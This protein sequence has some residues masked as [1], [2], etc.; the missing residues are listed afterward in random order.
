MISQNSISR[1]SFWLS[2]LR[3]VWLMSITWHAKLQSSFLHGWCTPC[4]RLTIL[5]SV[6]L[7]EWY[8]V[9]IVWSYFCWLL[10]Q[11]DSFCLCSSWAPNKTLSFAIQIVL[12]IAQSW[13]SWTKA[14]KVGDF[15]ISRNR[16]LP[17]KQIPSHEHFKAFYDVKTIRLIVVHTFLWFWLWKMN[18][19]NY[20]WDLLRKPLGYVM[21]WKLWQAT[22]QSD[23]TY[24]WKDSSL[25]PEPTISSVL[26]FSYK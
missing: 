13:C 8:L 17:K 6:C 1:T 14:Y 2:Y 5:L 21:D 12:W 16:S 25:Y 19:F 3:S 20:S 22:L 24:L 18:F 10:R 15:M 11:V 9:P 26:A 23:S 4:L 7:S